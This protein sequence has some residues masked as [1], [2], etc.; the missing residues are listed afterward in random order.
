M[1]RL[2]GREF[3]KEELQAYTGNLAQ[4]GGIRAVELATG[5]E[6]GV[7]AFDVATGSGFEFTVLADRALDISRAVFRGR[8]LAVHSPG[9]QAHPA[10]Y[11]SQGLG[12]LRTFPG[13]LVTTCGLSWL[14]APCSDEGEEL[15]LHGRISTLPAEE[16]GFW[17]EWKD[18]DYWMYIKGTMTEGVFFGN[19]LRLTRQISSKL[20]SNSFTI[21]D[22]VENLGGQPTPLMVLYHCNIGFPL[23][24]PDSSLV[25]NS[26]NISPRDTEG[27]P[28]LAHHAEFQAPTP[29]YGEQ[30]FYHD[31]A[32]DNNGDVRVALINPQL[33]GGLGVFMKYHKKSLPRFVQWKMMGHGTYVLGLEPSNCGVEG[34]AVERG[35]GTLQMLQ[36]GEQRT[37]HLELGVLDGTREIEEFTRAIKIGA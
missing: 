33:D 22:T 23:L 2:F 4:V 10:Y 24:G 9:G 7:R 27:A 34:R 19:P 37:F 11:E 17:G 31:M 32:T 1:V 12:W 15:G 36:P 26:L 30:V 25:T 35:R 14:G 21:D 18:N 16:L 28:G 20:G 13:G 6:R 5:R 3:S 8:S 29:G